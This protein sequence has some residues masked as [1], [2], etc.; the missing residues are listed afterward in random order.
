MEKGKFSGHCR[1]SNPDSSAVQ[2][3][4]I[5]TELYRFPTCMFL[6]YIY[7]LYYFL[8][9]GSHKKYLSVGML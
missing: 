9:Y 8:L 4:A 6:A 2:L 1:E 3:V 7:I 5:P